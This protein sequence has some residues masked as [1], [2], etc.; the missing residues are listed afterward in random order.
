MNTALPTA[1]G[2][3][4]PLITPVNEDGNVDKLSLKKVIRHC[5]NSGVDGVF[6]GGSSGMGP[7]L[8]DRQWQIAMETARQ[9]T[10]SEVLLLGGVIC[11]SSR[12]AV[13]KIKI[14]EKTG[15]KHIAVTPTYYITLTRDDQFLRHFDICRQATDMDM[16]VYNIPSCT[17]S[18]IPLSVI[19]K[20]G[21][22]GWFNA[23]KESSGD[24]D[25]FQSAM[26]IL[27]PYD[28]D[29]LQG[30]EPDIE[31]A[32]LNGAGGI[33]PVCA[34]YEPST[35]VTAWNASQNRDK[36]ILQD[37]QKRID[38]IRDIM[39]VQ[40]E[41]WIAGVMYALSTQNIG[42]GKPLAPLNEISQESKKLIDNLEI[43]DISKGVLNEIS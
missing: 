18:R 36:K 39:I 26:K 8:T 15:F 24:R 11:T 10:D 28:I 20:M 6:I 41:N 9:E 3:I 5:I 34:N 42:N 32:L 31:W 25:Y 40:S 13:E 4:V 1:K 43:I 21:R 30:N 19:E 35:F 14:L 27:Q 37:A 12:I 29:I 22:S 38:H 33:V 23:M 2:V 7:L 17:N 16:V